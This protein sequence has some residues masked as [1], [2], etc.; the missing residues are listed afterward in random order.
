MC[1]L[2]DGAA[3]DLGGVR[4]LTFLYRDG[5]SRGEGLLSGTMNR[6]C[7]LPDSTGSISGADSLVAQ[8]SFGLN[9]IPEGAVINKRAK[10]RK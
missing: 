4:G 6:S 5:G 8:V 3:G 9:S 10:L 2:G 7:S 1:E